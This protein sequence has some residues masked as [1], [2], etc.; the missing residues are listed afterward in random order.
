MHFSP[1]FASNKLSLYI[2]NTLCDNHLVSESAFLLQIQF[3]PS[4]E[5]EKEGHSCYVNMSKG[6][7][8]WLCG[9]NPH[10]QAYTQLNIQSLMRAQ[11]AQGDGLGHRA[12]WSV[13]IRLPEFQFPHQQNKTNSSALGLTRLTLW[14]FTHLFNKHFLSS[15]PM[16]QHCKWCCKMTVR[17]PARW[18]SG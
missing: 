9:R 13:P 6:T 8:A 3:C 15:S 16:N 1:P 5:K 17:V 10:M 12:M 11:R 18:C 2:S 14:Q 7:E 4:G